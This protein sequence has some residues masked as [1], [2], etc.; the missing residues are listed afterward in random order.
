MQP[1]E[2]NRLPISQTLRS[3]DTNTPENELPGLLVR[4]SPVP[5]SDQITVKQL[6]VELGNVR[7]QRIETLIQNGY[8]RVMRPS[9]A[10]H[11]TVVAR[12]SPDA[13]NWLRTMLAPLR[14]RPLLPLPELAE[15]LGMKIDEIRDLCL[16]YE[17]PIYSDEVFGELLSLAGYRAFVHAQNRLRSPTRTDRQ[18]LMVLMVNMRCEFPK[19]VIKKSY[20]QEL[21]EL[22]KQIVVM[23]EPRRTMLSAEFWKAYKDAE[24]IADCIKTIE[25]SPRAKMSDASKK[26]REL[27]EEMRDIAAGRMTPGPKQ[28]HRGPKGAHLRKLWRDPEWRAKQTAMFKRR[29]RE[30]WDKYRADQAAKAPKKLGRP[31]GSKNRSKATGEAAA[32]GPSSS[33][34]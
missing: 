25:T 1:N 15:F 32:G 18:A 9:Q 22:I 12:P 6:A 13:L 19:S 30:R 24:T 11:E 21:E 17:I 16:Y 28:R 29:A 20:S 33:G 31:L 34:S 23:P 7:W 8:L 4:K 14:K 10:L 2:I 5:A 26:I 3:F 27:F